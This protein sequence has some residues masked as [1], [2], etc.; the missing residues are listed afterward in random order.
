M[1]SP[2]R[3]LIYCRESRDENALHYERI[4]VQRDILLQFCAA[5]GLSNIVQIIMDDN[6]SGTSFARLLQVERMAKTGAVNTLV[7]KDS[8]RLGRNLRE[9]L[10][11][12][13]RMDE[14]G[15]R[16]LFES[17]RFDPELFPLLAWFHEQ[18]AREDSRKVRRVLQHK[19]QSGELLIRAPY[20]YRKDGGNLLPDPIPAEG[21]ERVFALFLAGYTTGEIA[22][23]LGRQGLPSPA[24]DPAAAW[25]RQH[26]YRILR[27]AVYTGEHALHKTSKISFRSKKVARLPRAEWYIHPQH[28]PALVSQDDFEKAQV[29]FARRSK[30]TTRHPLS[31]S[32][33]LFCGGC[34]RPMVQRRRAGR[35]ACYVCAAYHQKGTQACASH[36][37]TQQELDNALGAFLQDYFCRHITL[38]DDINALLHPAAM[39]LPALRQLRQTYR[40]ALGKIYDDR[41]CL[42]AQ[43]P[44]GFYEEKLREYGEKLAQLDGRI[45]RA[46]A[47]GPPS[48]ALAQWLC[49]LQAGAFPSSALSRI[50]TRGECYLPGDPPAHL[51][52]RLG[53]EAFAHLF[54]QGGVVFYLCEW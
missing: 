15:V 45:A 42:G 11:F 21:V 1:N 40:N 5:Q 17:E 38:P 19:M 6:V 2:E 39:Q 47:S 34:A 26:V 7:F 37:V 51:Q 46:S 18:R 12:L 8:S 16:V 25:N 24:P 30:R 10:N 3:V 52:H 13:H 23:E 36:R 43:T 20:G 4:E 28:H 27:S 54:Q 14:L 49:A 22:A 50:I 32:G 29:L 48:A 35:A 33:L 53:Q 44:A 31:F 41:L 9:S